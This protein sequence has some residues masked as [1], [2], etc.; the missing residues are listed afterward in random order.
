VPYPEACVALAGLV[1]QVEAG[2]IP[3]NEA[4][5]VHVTGGGHDRSVRDLGKI[6]YPAGAT[7][8]RDDLDAALGAV[9]RYLGQ[10][11]DRPR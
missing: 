7:I 8:R 6:P 11:G 1:K 10:A 9:D 2:R 5:L 4:V 3:R